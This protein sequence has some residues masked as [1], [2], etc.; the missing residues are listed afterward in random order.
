M[1]TPSNTEITAVDFYWRPGCGFCTSLNRRL[2]GAGVPLAKH[3]I[4]EDDQARDYV[5]SVA[6]GHETVPT[7]AVGRQVMVNPSAREVMAALADRAP[8]L[9]PE[10]YDTDDDGDGSHRLGRLIHRV[11]GG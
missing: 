4:W 6:R 9:L 5:R 1:A 3:N 11:L 2:E 8:H 7:V 10:E